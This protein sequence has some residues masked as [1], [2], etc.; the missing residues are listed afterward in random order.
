MLTNLSPTSRVP[1][2]S[3]QCYSYVISTPPDAEYL[4]SVIERLDWK[5]LEHRAEEKTTNTNAQ[6]KNFRVTMKSVLCMR[7]IT[8]RKN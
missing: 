2:P 1:A 3:E 7:G 8:K 4:Y 6:V 5:I